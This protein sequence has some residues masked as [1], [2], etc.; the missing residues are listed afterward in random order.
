MTERRSA[1]SV[2]PAMTRWLPA[3]LLLL[4]GCARGPAADLQY[5]K[6]ARS[7]AAE[8][9]LVNE[10]A[11]RGQL[12]AHYADG[13]RAAAREELDSAAAALSVPSA[14]YAAEIAALRGEPDDA[15]A[16]RLRAHAGRLKQFE[17]GIESA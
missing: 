9:A 17:S 16:A 7:A 8:W 4:A 3:L 2:L 1:A 5:I 15:P 12:T 11:A 13:M 10:R 14:P 6:Q